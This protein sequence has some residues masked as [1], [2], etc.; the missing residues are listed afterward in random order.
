MADNQAKKEQK[1]KKTQA[2]EDKAA[3]AE[4]RRQNS[5]KGKSFEDMLVYVDEFGNFSSSP[6][7]PLKK[8]DIDPSEIVFRSVPQETTVEDVEKSRKGQ[9]TY[10]ASAKRFGFITDSETGERVF[11][12][13]SELLQP[14]QEG[15]NV[16]YFKERNDKGSFATRVALV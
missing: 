15:D 3:R 4:K 10:Y 11:V 12:H 6:P 16:T 9:I 5:N 2:K 7:D 8:R 1:K 14:V 13:A